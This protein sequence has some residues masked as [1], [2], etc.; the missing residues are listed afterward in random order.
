MSRECTRFLKTFKLNYPIVQAPMAGVSTPEMASAVAASGGLGSLTLSH[1][2]LQ[3]TS[4]V[5]AIRKAVNSFLSTAGADPQKANLNF[6]CHPIY[7]IPTVRQKENW[8]NLYCEVLE[9]KD[10]KSPLKFDNGNVSFKSIETQENSDIFLSLLTFFETEFTPGVVSFHFG[11]PSS[12]SIQKL[13]KL[14]IAIFVTATSEFE[15]EELLK[16]GV[17][18][19]ICQGYEAG[20]HRGCFPGNEVH[21][22]EGLSTLCLFKR[23]QEAKNKLGSEAFLIPAGGIMDSRAIQFYLDQG[24]SACQLGTAFLAAAES[25]SSK[26]YRDLIKSHHKISTTLTPFPSGLPAR[27]LQTPFI[28][29]LASLSQG[30]DLPPYGYRYSEFKLL[31]SKFPSLVNFHLCGQGVNQIQTGRDKCLSTAEIFS[32]LTQD[33]VVPAD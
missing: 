28:E 1:V 2:D 27:T 26:F 13:K 33:L 3:D 5:S 9:T 30:K 21:L 12:S 14:G 10:L 17:D 25:K 32:R 31:R 4:A 18:G 6:F 23:L 20:G 19:I 15:G 8:N 29:R 22:D 11:C 16:L 24:A 7:P